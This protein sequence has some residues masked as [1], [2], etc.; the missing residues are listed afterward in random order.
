MSTYRL[1]SSLMP[2]GTTAAPMSCS[3]ASA[4]LGVGWGSTPR[5]KTAPVTVY[6]YSHPLSLPGFGRVTGGYLCG[7]TSPSGRLGPWGAYYSI[8]NIP[9]VQE[10]C[11][12]KNRPVARMFIVW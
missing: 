7:A 11:E 4:G 9:G 2:T 8:T 1:L 5:H 12:R 6:G 10:G 3:G